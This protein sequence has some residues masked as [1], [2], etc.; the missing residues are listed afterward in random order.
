M[1]ALIGPGVGAARSR[2]AFRSVNRKGAPGY[3]PG[4]QRHHLLP[5]QLLAAHC[6]EPLFES[7]FT[8]Q[9]GYVTELVD[10]IKKLKA[11]MFAKDK[12][13]VMPPPGTAFMNRLQFGFY[14]VLAR[15]D[16]EVDYAAVERDF[17]RRGGVA[18]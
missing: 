7:P 18:V 11:E 10:G 17:L 13:F 2:I 6:F 8:M 4:M 14:S 16:V 12:S 5:R 1:P 3:H 9:G 15:L